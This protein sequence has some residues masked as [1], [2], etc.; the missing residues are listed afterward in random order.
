MRPGIEDLELNGA[1]R[2]N[3]G[4]SLRPEFEDLECNGA[5]QR[6]LEIVCD[7]N[8]G[9]WSE[10]VQFGGFSEIVSDQNPRIWSKIVQSGRF[11][12]IRC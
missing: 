5:S 3:A 11:S 9:I 6:I 10:T 2:T 7:Q 8:S 12:E 4:D 1:V